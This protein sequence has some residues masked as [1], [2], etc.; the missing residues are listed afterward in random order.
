MLKPD[1]IKTLISND[2]ASDRKRLAREGDRYFN[3]NHD[4]AKYRIF[5]INA[6]GKLQED[7]TRSNIRISHPFWR[8]L[9]EQE[10]QYIL[11]GKEPL[12]NSDIP[13]LQTWLD[14]YFND[15]DDFN[16]ELYYAVLGAIV[17]GCDFFYAYKNSEGKDV[18]IQQ[19]GKNGRY[20]G[21][22]NLVFE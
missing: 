21:F 14:E 12:F 2:K 4:I 7:L 5:F 3:G 15:N 22:A 9:S 20:L 19:M 10:A 11:S 8:I 6:D 13:E 17:K 18:I 1:E 16:S